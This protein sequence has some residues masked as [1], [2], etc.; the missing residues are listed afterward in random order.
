VIWKYQPQA[1]LQAQKVN[2][3]FSFALIVKII[4]TDNIYMNVALE[5]I[6]AFT[7]STITYIIS[8]LKCICNS[9]SSFNETEEDNY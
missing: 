7:A 9:T 3:W 5:T 2:Y 1:K 4:F 8:R 6:I